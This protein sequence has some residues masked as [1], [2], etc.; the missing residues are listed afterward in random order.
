LL[1]WVYYSS[2]I[3]YIG[4]ELTKSYA[5]RFGSKIYPNDYAVT[6]QSVVIE[7]E[8]KSIQKNEKQKKETPNVK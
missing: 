5:V 8:N 6:V 2:I 7:D 3:L 1:I 4:A